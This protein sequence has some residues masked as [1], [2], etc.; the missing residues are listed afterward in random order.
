ME[1]KNIETFIKKYSLGG[2]IEQVRW[3]IKD[4]TVRVTSMTSDK[5]FLTNV[6]MKD[7]DVA[8]TEIGVMSSAKFKQMIGALTEKINWTTVFD[9][10]DTT[11]VTGVDISDDKTEISVMSADLDVIGAEP[12]LKTI[13]SFDVEI[14]LTEDFV[15]RFLK[16]KS[17]LPESDL[18]T[19]NMSKKKQK[20]ELVIGYNKNNSNRISLDVPAA[21][22]KDTVKSPISFSAKN[23]KE[24]LAVNPEGK[25]PV[26][27][28]S[29]AGLAFVEFDQDGFQSQ[30]YMIKIEVED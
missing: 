29:E 19:L 8:D 26:L 18:F 20:L 9:E 1:K 7:F 2:L 13:P 22:G 30:Y 14:T 23:L 10:T 4:K 6:V 17:A 28:V 11:R 24:I 15:S 12:K 5:K 21:P 25:D 16:A 3:V 27:K